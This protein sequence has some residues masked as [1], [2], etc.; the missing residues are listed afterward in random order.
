MLV[1]EY[2]ISFLKSIGIR[3]VFGYQGGSI[4]H[5]I[6]A[7]GKTEGIE[8]IQNYHEQASA[9]C[10]EGYSRTSKNGIGAV[11]ASNGPGALNL[12]TGIADAYCD[13]I[14]IIVITGQVR[15][16][17]IRR[18]DKIRQ[19]S[20]Q[21]IDI[22]GIV[23]SVTKYCV[24][25]LRPED[26]RLELEKAYQ[27]A[28][29]GR[30]G[31][32]LVDLPV[33]I[34]QMEVEPDT[35]TGM[36][37]K[38][39]K[40]KQIQT[41]NAAQL[42]QVIQLLEKAQRP[43]VLAGGGIRAGGCTE[44]FQEF[45]RLTG[46]PVVSSLMGLDAAGTE[47]YGFIGM[48]GN[49]WANLAIQNADILL[50]MG[51]RLDSRQTGKEKNQFAPRADIIQ[52]DID[53]YELEHQIPSRIAFY[54]DLTDFL[55][56]INEK[57]CSQNW[58]NNW[59][60]W[61]SL[62]ARWKKRFQDTGIQDK[63]L[64]PNGLLREIFRYAK[65]NAVFTSDVGQNQ[66]WAAQSVQLH[67][68]GARILNSGGLGAMG[69]SLPACIGAYYSGQF[70]QHICFTGDG[71]LQMNLQELCLIGHKKIPIKIVLM[72]N[73]SL[74]MIR[75]MQ[76]KY[77]GGRYIGSV[78][79]FD[80]PDFRWI[81]KANGLCYKTI[82]TIKELE[83]SREILADGR[84]W[85][86]DC[87]LSAETEIVPELIGRDGLDNQYPYLEDDEKARICQEIAEIYRER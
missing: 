34:Q 68:G 45:I 73:R 5:L 83:L 75:D 79:G 67:K 74:G 77:Y 41:T 23:R 35:L 87:V 48:Y 38:D 84:P 31:P 6:D 39:R 86:I 59:V 81:A 76:K 7:L 50:V 2:V 72:N 21:E 11:V 64:P 62:L 49:R 27:I 60:R 69:F 32:V 17:A 8:Y 46:I 37:W 9:F 47:L 14:P 54:A 24:T 42:E 3:Y 10:A 58:E 1:S 15:R 65:G 63:E 26:I 22:I 51:S 70:E 44:K 57:I 55:T 16:E 12:L 33:D 28:M 80:Q 71:G 61:R 29:G 20:F 25:V 53:P 85:L 52:I 13:S 43:L 66:M 36:D 56:D 30:P 19:E 78:E 18:T 4:T 40:K 82:H